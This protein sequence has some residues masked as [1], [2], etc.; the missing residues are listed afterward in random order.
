MTTESI[1]PANGAHTTNG[2]PHGSTSITPHIVVARA[3]DAIA[4]YTSVLGAKLI[5][6]T[7]FP[8]SDEVAHAVLD[9]GTGMITLSDPIP[10]YGLVATDAEKGAAYSLA[11][12]VPNTDE[13]TA[14][15]EAAGA[16]VR[17]KPA[18]FVSGDRYS[19]VLD[20]FGVRWSIMTRVEDLSYEEGARR[21]AEWAASQG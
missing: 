9:F 4:F 18:T 6:L 10:S 16:T 17:E 20:P 3:G 14:A 5:D 7:R 12:Y 2:M 21:V 1:A 19:S 13:V 15:A 8:N 11:L